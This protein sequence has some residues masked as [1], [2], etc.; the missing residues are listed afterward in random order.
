[1]GAPWNI[2]MEFPGLVLDTS[3]FTQSPPPD[4]SATYDMLI[5]GGGPAAMS[6]AVYAARKMLKIAIITLNFGGQLKE[7]SFVENY[8]GF[9]NIHANDLVS[10]FDD[11]VKSFSLPV[12]IGAAIK[13]VRK[14]DALFSVL[15]EDGARFSGK[16][17]IFATGETHRRL[18]ISGEEEF[19]GR[20]VSY[21][22]TCDAPLY[23]EKKV[24]VVGGGNSA[25][26]T[27]LDLSRGNAEIVLVNI[28]QGWHADAFLREKI[29]GYEKAELLDLYELVS[30]EG[31]EHVESVVL[32][33]HRT[34][35]ERTVPVDGIFIEI[36]LLPNSRPAA[37]LVKLNE[38]GEVVIDC[39]CRTNVPGFFA[40]GDV[41]TVP[42]KQIIIS[43]G[44]GAKAALT[45][46]SYLI[47]T[48]QI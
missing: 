48:A 41:T 15:M 6:A 44:E 21:C 4:R 37:D 8:L 2:R 14:E 46:Y 24:L 20:G 10:R 39:L 43:A 25:F 36:G 22:A 40:A 12:G 3:A 26:T 23:R 31:K 1:M 16:T 7:T 28:V 13:E 5:L 17:I 27:A 34:G 32:K 35:E 47:E 29:E 45:A 19:M 33:D 18:K 9:Q 38:I 30:I 11:H 42:H